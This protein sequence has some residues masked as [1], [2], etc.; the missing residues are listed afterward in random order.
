MRSAIII[1]LYGLQ[2]YVTDFKSIR[3][4]VLFFIEIGIYNE[5]E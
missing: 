1:V 3:F 5:K 4:R 2:S